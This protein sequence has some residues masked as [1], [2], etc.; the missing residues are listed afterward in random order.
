MDFVRSPTRESQEPV[1]SITSSASFPSAVSSDVPEGIT[2][3]RS[4]P[5]QSRLTVELSRATGFDSS[6]YQSVQQSQS[7][8]YSSQPVSELE[9]QDRRI[10][11]GS[12]N[13]QKTIPDSQGTSKSDII[14]E[15]VGDPLEEHS[16]NTNQ[17]YQ[18]APQET[19]PDSQSQVPEPAPLNKTAN[20][21]TS[22]PVQS[23][24]ASSSAP[25]EVIPDSTDANP[26]I[27]SRQP[28]QLDTNDS[29]DQNLSEERLSGSGE[30][31]E[32]EEVTDGEEV[33]A[34]QEVPEREEG[35]ERAEG[36]EREEVPE[37]EEAFERDDVPQKEERPDREEGQEGALNTEHQEQS[38]PVFI[39]QPI[40]PEYNPI[41]SSAQAEL[42]TPREPSPQLES[43]SAPV[44]QHHEP[45]QLPASQ[46]L[47]PEHHDSPSPRLSQ[48]A[49]PAKQ[50]FESFPNNL[51]GS[52]ETD[53]E[54]KFH[55]D[56][57]PLASSVAY[58]SESK[59][60]PPS[61]SL[62]EYS[63]G[64]LLA[65]CQDSQNY[66]SDMFGTGPNE[67]TSSGRPSALAEVR[68][69]WDDEPT[70][71]SAD[72]N[73]A[74]EAKPVPTTESMGPPSSY[75]AEANVGSSRLG[76]V[77]FFSQP[78]PESQPWGNDGSSS[79]SREAPGPAAPPGS[80]TEMMRKLLNED[81]NEPQNVQP[82]TV[83]PADVSLP[84][85]AE[86]L[87]LPVLT[88]HEHANSGLYDS[89]GHS[90]T[91]AQLPQTDKDVSPR[92]SESEEVGASYMVTLPF[93][94]SIRSLYDEILFK[95]R[96]DVTKFT[97]VFTTEILTEPEL[98]LINTIDNLFHQL[99]NLCD[100][101]ENVLEGPLRDIPVSQKVRYYLDANAKMNFLYEFL[102]AIAKDTRILIVA[103]SSDLLRLVCDIAEALQLECACEA[104]GY[105]AP[106]PESPVRLTLSLLSQ[107]NEIDA[108][109]YDVVIGYDGSFSDS[110][111]FHQLNDE[112]TDK[113]QPLVLR[114]ITTYSIEH[115]EA[116]LPPT[117]NELEHK[118]ALLLSIVNARP[119][120][121]D[122]PRLPQPPF[123]AKIFSDY[124]NDE[125]QSIAWDP[126]PIPPSVVDVYANSQSL[127][128]MP[129]ESSFDPET[130]GR[131]RK[132][133][134]AMK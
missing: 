75:H 36:P 56:S 68:A 51:I 35:L 11:L 117:A 40:F 101:P 58:E 109:Q 86:R 12:D 14:G 48:A 3:P 110:A 112:N 115:I 88:S 5:N 126:E 20:N 45:S 25:E 28:D 6:E 124:V 27:P 77:D 16:Q 79:M 24:T 99:R 67:S 34:R 46:E 37:R 64:I 7:S 62:P 52:V 93:Q 92:S 121:A 15:P 33:A 21:H 83:S 4:N 29:A 10:A 1:P 50:D 89:S 31:H 32:S 108:R 95:N 43:S 53:S 72:R 30:I 82:A 54:R 116:E 96:S 100:Y 103:R 85:E 59:Y 23:E 118:S 114:L 87:T 94:A 81:Y 38:Q 106:N 57:Q 17:S 102:Q 134:S 44:P 9:A 91:L 129:R 63:P 26:D 39:T 132:I 123:V 84:S 74:S 105:S 128:Q 22:N 70:T 127:S 8:P 120:L 18:S 80:A 13:S 42:Q 71:K 131:K 119:L 125:V 49:Q 55:F 111:F 60:I 41:S 61:R 113:K 98:S 76:H 97:D 90:I 2:T 130:G 78:P 69:L 122:P 73:Q 47:A 104:L 66:T 107:S 65:I 133:V 19:V